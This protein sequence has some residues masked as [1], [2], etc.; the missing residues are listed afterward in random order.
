MAML[1]PLA[2]YVCVALYA[3]WGSRLKPRVALA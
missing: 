1:V 2:C 3:F